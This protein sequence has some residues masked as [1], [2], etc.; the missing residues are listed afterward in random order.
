MIQV[1]F[2]NLEPSDFARQSAIQ[3]LEALAEKFEDLSHSKM[4]VTL[5]MHN[6][7]SQPGPDE[8]SVSVRI[9]NGRYRGI[10]ISKSADNIYAALADVV[11]HLLEMLNRFGD[12]KRVKARSRA[13]KRI[14]DTRRW[15][16]EHL[17]SEMTEASHENLLRKTS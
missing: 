17:Q 4:Q 10:G 12:R 6:A 2:K 16:S 3:R 8:F 5:E 11:D 7:P 1:V 14:K 9:K 15:V 13:R